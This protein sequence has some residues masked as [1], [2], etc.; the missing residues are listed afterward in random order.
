MLIGAV[1]LLALLPFVPGLT[2]SVATPH[3]S[4]QVPSAGAAPAGGVAPNETLNATSGSLRLNVSLWYSPGPSSFGIKAALRFSGGQAPYTVTLAWGA[5]GSWDYTD[6]NASANTTYTFNGSYNETN[7]YNVS[8]AVQFSNPPRNG[9]G[10]YVSTSVLALVPSSPLGVAVSEFNSGTNGTPATDFR[11]GPAFGGRPNYTLVIEFGDGSSFNRSLGLLQSGNVLHAYSAA[12]GATSFPVEVLLEDSA[13]TWYNQ[14]FSYAPSY[15]NL[16]PT[17]AS[18]CASAAYC[19]QV[20]G[21]TGN[22]SVDS[23][24]ILNRSAGPTQ[25]LWGGLDGAVGSGTVSYSIALGD[26]NTISVGSIPWN[27]SYEFSHSYAL[28]ATPSN[29]TWSAV[30]NFSGGAAVRLQATL[31]LPASSNNSSGGSGSSGIRQYYCGNATCEFAWSTLGPIQY[32]ATLRM[33]NSSGPYPLALN[34]TLSRGAYPYVV[35]VGFGD[36]GGANATLGNGSGGNFQFSHLYSYAGLYQLGLDARDASN[37]TLQ[38]SIPVVVPGSNTSGRNNSSGS[39]PAPVS[40]V[41]YPNPV[42]GSSPLTVNFEALIDGGS[43][44]FTVRW[45]LP[46]GNGS[47]PSNVTGL[48]VSATYSQS[49]WFPA[50]AFVYNTTNAYGTV[51]V[52]YGSVWVYVTPSGNGSSGGQSGG[53]SSGNHSVRPGGESPGAAGAPLTLNTLLG[54]AGPLAILLALGLG[55]L[56]GA[57]LGFAFGRGSRR[58]EPRA[59]EPPP[60]GPPG[61]GPR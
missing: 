36:G 53:N 22:F 15:L 16:P 54:S 45:S 57:I 23:I 18:A 40:V 51:L 56:S 25:P 9:S 52:G 44:P 20:N 26:N 41:V 46:N 42:T 37:G 19:A 38:A 33:N 50:T 32:R 43:P 21:R 7:R 24:L 2:S 12:S 1:A 58:P 61:A 14:S 29:V 59:P 47:G 55:A 39:Y 13:G 10:A 6:S 30:A 8:A 5:S 3:A 60:L 27:E 49:G 11:Y 34:G 17:L 28:G 48:S 4:A 31:P 35:S